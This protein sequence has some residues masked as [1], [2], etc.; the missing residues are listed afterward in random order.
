MVYCVV[1]DCNNNSRKATGLSYD[2]FPKDPS[3]REQWLVKICQADLAFKKTSGCLQIISRL[4]ATSVSS[5]PNSLVQK[6]ERPRE[7]MLFQR[8]SLI[9]PL[10]T[11][12]AY[13]L[14]TVPFK[15]PVKRSEICKM[16]FSTNW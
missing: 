12:L 7:L 5:R 9:G 10:V 15:K 3:L 4:T 11:S 1:F 6:R 14:R 13:C 8:Y 16:S 2:C